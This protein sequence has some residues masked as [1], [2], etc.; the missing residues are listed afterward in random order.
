MRL[1]LRSWLRDSPVVALVYIIW[2]MSNRIS[3]AY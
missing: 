2:Q 1:G 3:V